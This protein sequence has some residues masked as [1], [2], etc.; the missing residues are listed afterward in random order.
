[1][2]LHVFLDVLDCWTL[3][4]ITLSLYCVVGI[5]NLGNFG[6]LDHVI[7][8]LMSG[9]ILDDL[10]LHCIFDLLFTWD[11]S[12][13]GECF[14]ILKIFGCFTCTGFTVGWTRVLATCSLVRQLQIVGIACPRLAP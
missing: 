3:I 8:F 5:L 7:D 14:L 12:S 10:D 13:L 6:L 9:R 1:M 2:N 4:S 11:L